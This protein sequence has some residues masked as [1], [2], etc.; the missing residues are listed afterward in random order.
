VS[1]ERARLDPAA[2]IARLEQEMDTLREQRDARA[3]LIAWG[4][5]THGRV[6]PRDIDAWRDLDTRHQSLWSEWMDLCERTG[7]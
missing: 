3:N 2:D 5:A 6:S 4:L 7:R 1:S